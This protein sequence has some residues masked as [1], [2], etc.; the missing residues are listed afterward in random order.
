MTEIVTCVRCGQRLHLQASIPHQPALLRR[1]QGIHRPIIPGCLRSARHLPVHGAGPERWTT[2]SL[3]RGT[4][5]WGSS[6]ARSLPRRKRP[7]ANEALMVSN[8]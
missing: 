6:S 1:R 7:G 8:M 3:N 4:P 2:R 5:P